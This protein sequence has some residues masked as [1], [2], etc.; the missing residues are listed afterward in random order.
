MTIDRSSKF[1]EYFL[2]NII[3][4]PTLLKYSN[5]CIYPLTSLGIIGGNSWQKGKF[6]KMTVSQAMLDTVETG[7]YYN[8]SSISDSVLATSD[9]L[10][11]INNYIFDYAMNYAQDSIENEAISSYVLK[12]LKF[13]KASNP[14]VSLCILALTRGIK[15]IISSHS[16]NIIDLQK[17]EKE[18]K[19]S[20]NNVSKTGKKRRKIFKKGKYS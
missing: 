13:I 14:I 10:N 16:N 6:D 17:I 1:I 4:N 19:T 2:P 8:I 18:K 7:I 11:N 20:I 3:T 12:S 15:E 9:T 5:S